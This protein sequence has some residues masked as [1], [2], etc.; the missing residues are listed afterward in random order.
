MAAAITLN[1]EPARAQ[2]PQRG[3]DED[4]AMALS[5]TGGE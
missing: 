1:V 4:A 2:H 3:Q 5:V